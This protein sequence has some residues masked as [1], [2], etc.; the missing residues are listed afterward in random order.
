MNIAFAERL[1]LMNSMFHTKSYFAIGAINKAIVT[2][3]C[4][5][6]TE[7][8]LIHWS[9]FIITGRSEFSNHAYTD[10]IEHL[11]VFHTNFTISGNA[12]FRNSIDLYGGAV[13]LHNYVNSEYYVWIQCGI[14]QQYGFSSG[15]CSL[16]V[17]IS[18]LYITKR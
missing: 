12:T 13:Y 14:H 10:G 15:R 17:I 9:N 2:D 16:C 8:I 18:F 4:F 7:R 3:C 1:I 11:G 6:N 5:Y